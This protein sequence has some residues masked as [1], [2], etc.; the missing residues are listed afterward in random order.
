MEKQALVKMASQIVAAHPD[1]ERMSPAEVLDELRST[2]D[3]LR[4]GGPDVT[5]PRGC[6]RLVLLADDE[7]SIRNFGRTVLERAGYE[8]LLAEDGLAALEAFHSRRDGVGAAVLD[9]NMPVM[10]GEE[11]F[12]GLRALRRGLPVLFCSGC[13]PSDAAERLQRAGASIIG[14]PFDEEE[15]LTA[16]GRLLRP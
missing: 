13:I 16:V 4:S 11:V 1:A 3:T 8:V 9:Y 12:R 14:K 15:F 10:T 7:P 6:R 2:F 5:P